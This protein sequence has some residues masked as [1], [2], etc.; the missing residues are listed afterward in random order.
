[1]KKIAFVDYYLGNWHA[2]NY[3]AWI[4]DSS[5]ELGIDI[6][7]YGAYAKR[8]VSPVNGVT[9]DKWCKKNKVKRFDD[10]D[11]LCRE[12]DGI[13]ILAPSNPEEHLPL[14][15]EVFK[16]GKPTYIDKTFAPDLKSAQQIFA[17]AK[18]NGVPFFSTSAL[19]Y[20]TELT[21]MKADKRIDI[22]GGGRSLEEY[23]I[24]QI[25]MLTLLSDGEP[26]EARAHINGGQTT[27]T[28]T[29]SDGKT[30]TLTHSPELAFTV[31]TDGGERTEIT[32][33]FLGGLIREIVRFLDTGAL[34]FDSSETLRAMKIRDAVLLAASRAG[35]KIIL[36]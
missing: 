27:V 32:S 9:T 4:K 23:V 14:V 13:V 10:L 33:S 6:A 7:L 24:H 12:A 2:D 8:D 34:P 16:H 18:K 20:A 35:E 30:A 29:L 22:S 15:S 17:L 19:R 21:G 11:A 26:T 25:E 31:S 36:K 5:S 1:M 28:L 3:P